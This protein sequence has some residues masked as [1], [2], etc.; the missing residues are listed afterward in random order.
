MASGSWDLFLNSWSKA[1]YIHQRY[2]SRGVRHLLSCEQG[3]LH[4]SLVRR[5]WKKSLKTS[6]QNIR[7]MSLYQNVRDKSTNN[8]QVSSSQVIQKSPNPQTPVVF[9]VTPL[10]GC[11]PWAP[12]P[13]PW[14]WPS[15][16]PRCRA[17]PRN[18]PAAPPVPGTVE[19]PTNWRWEKVGRFWMKM[20]GWLVT[21]VEHAWNF[22]SW[23]GFFSGYVTWW[24]SELFVT[25]SDF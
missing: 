16:P 6:T 8:N 25:S 20:E 11:A 12:A 14:P 18:P 13:W 1:M 5:G 22:N 23:F 24:Y 17:P 15:G 19:G 10:A 2:N 9:R 3:C 4:P 7:N 21:F